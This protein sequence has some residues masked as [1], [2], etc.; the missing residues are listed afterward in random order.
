MH[1]PKAASAL[2]RIVSAIACVSIDFA[3]AGLAVPGLIVGADIPE[4]Q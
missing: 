1:G 4:H 2:L 3:Y